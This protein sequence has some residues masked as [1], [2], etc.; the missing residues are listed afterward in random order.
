MKSIVLSCDKYHPMTNH[1]ILTYQKLWPSNNLEFLVPWNE[2][3]PNHMIEDY[4]DSKVRLIN[5]SVEFK[6]TI[7]GLLDGVDDNEWIFWASDDTYLTKIDEEKANKVHSFV[8]SLDD[9]KKIGVTFGYIRQVPTNS[10][11]NNFL[12]YDDVRFIKRTFLTNQWAHQYWRAWV[13][14]YMFD[15]I[16]EAPK[17]QAKAMD[18]M[19]GT[20]NRFWDILTR[21]DM[22]TL[23]HNIATW[24]ESTIRGKMAKSCFDSF[25]EYGLDIP[26]DFEQTN[27]S[28]YFI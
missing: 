13:L 19:L 14:R 16:E 12:D 27:E 22:Y 15:C 21:G 10:D 18:G 1:M 5:T 9:N 2:K 11:K 3:K 7:S 23:D 4:G 6:K 20:K 17:Y 24:G 28:K 8:K 25:N 26:K